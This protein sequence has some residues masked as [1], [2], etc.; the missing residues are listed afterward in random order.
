MKVM[1][2]DDEPIVTT[3]LER[4]IPWREHGFEWAGNAENGR[5]ALQLILRQPPDLIL[6]D[7]RMPVMDGLELLR[8]IR[9]RNL[10]IKSVI[11]SGYDEFTY[12]QQ[13]LKL[14]A[15]DYLLKPPDLDKLLEVVLR[16]RKEWQEERQLRQQ[17]REHFPAIRERFLHSLLEGAGIPAAEFSSK[18]EYLGLRLR[19]GAFVLALLEISEWPE[20]L[21]NCRY[22]EEQLIRFAVQNIVEETL[23]EWKFQAVFPDKHGQLVILVNTEDDGDGSG[24]GAGSGPD[25]VHGE[26][27]GSEP[28]RE[29]IMKRLEDDLR[30]A[31][32]NIRDT[33]DI[34]TTIG[35]SRRWDDLLTRC[36][37]A[38][39][40]AHAA[41]QYTYYLGTGEVIKVEDW[42]LE[43]EKADGTVL[44]GDE[45]LHLAI[46]VCNPDD[47][48]DWID[49]LS[50]IMRTAGFPIDETKTISL[51]YMVVA[52]HTML[53][54]HPQLGIGELL[55]AERIHCVYA[56]SSLE[57]LLTELETYLF[58][59]ID[60]SRKLRDP[61]RNTVV[62]QIKRYIEDHYH[63]NISLETISK[64]VY[65]SPVYLSFLFKQVES[66]SLT[67]YITHIRIEK[68]K[69][70]LRST[71]AK[72]YEISRKV[73][74]QDEK[75]FSRVFKKKVGL[76]PTEYR[77]QHVHM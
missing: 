68:A 48:R 19:P 61:Q 75:Y 42:T 6:V 43:G 59:L 30:R 39:D 46:K 33:L 76:T 44:P 18:A 71:A 35:V 31:I 41:L 23:A 66:I 29:G 25:R 32:R 14:G 74:Y 38:R 37:I 15:S 58:S 26:S 53:G 22:E 11:L 73:G 72:T 63:E 60:L 20:K 40:E 67:D 55:S 21:Q 7:C 10:P 9:D 8:E 54:I 57:E 27:R 16:V 77:N 65:L 24:G 2:I 13:A 69:E 17:L 45:K 51:R 1:V 12:A 34:M 5:Q 47:L 64:T 4:L 49:G 28:Y 62:E 50:R 3:A 56:A 52:A 36:L 70:L